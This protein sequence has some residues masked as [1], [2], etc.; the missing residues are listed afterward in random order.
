[1]DAERRI[2]EW[3]LEGDPSIRYQTHR[4]ILHSDEEIISR[5]QKIIAE[6]GWGAK[7]L[8]YRDPNGT[9]GGGL[10]SPKWKSTTY[11][12]ILLKRLG[13]PASDPQAVKSCEVLIN[14]GYYKDKGI[15][16]FGSLEHSE[17]CVTGIILS[18]LSYFECKDERINDFAEYLVSQQMKDGGWN[19]QT[20]YGA[21]H[22]SFHTT[23]NVLEGLL[24]YQKKYKVPEIT[25]IRNKGHEFLLGHR[26]YKSDKTGNIIDPKMTRFSFPP[27]WRYD[28]MRLMDY[29]RDCGADYDERMEE[30]LNL[31]RKKR[32][33]DGTWDLQQKYPG[34][35]FFELEEAGK[36]SRINTLRGLRIL[37]FYESQPVSPK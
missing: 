5:E 8:S 12:M 37:N 26:L 30:T 28:I 6:E 14:K 17:T 15:N 25:E 9:W 21:T 7:L 36:P 32:N 23:V 3:L 1:M 18:I 33:K 24:E 16:F 10:Y 29:F 20:Y 27:R 11:T 35:T 31:I 19:C 4:D 13:L 34:K 22:G 2:V